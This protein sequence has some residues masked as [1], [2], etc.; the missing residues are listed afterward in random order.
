MKPYTRSAA[1]TA[2]ARVASS[3]G[4]SLQEALGSS[5]R[6]LAARRVCLAAM[7]ASLEAGNC[8]EVRAEAECKL[9]EG[10]G[11]S[12]TLKLLAEV[13]ADIARLAA[14]VAALEVLI[15]VASGDNPALRDYKK[16]QLYRGIR[17]ML[18][19]RGLR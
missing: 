10:W 5:S 9:R 4:L 18:A 11:V 13:Q 19:K 3:P 6:S 2:L 7:H 16:L 15:E 14:I 8:S 12:D 17:H 1:V